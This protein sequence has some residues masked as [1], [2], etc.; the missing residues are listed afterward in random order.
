VSRFDTTLDEISAKDKK[1]LLTTLDVANENV[2]YSDIGK[3][4]QCPKIVARRLL[5]N[6]DLQ[7]TNPEKTF[8]IKGAKGLA[9]HL[10]NCC[11]PLPDDNIVAHIAPNS[12]LMIHRSNCVELNHLSASN[13][14]TSSWEL[15]DDSLFLV[16]I[17]I[18]VR[19]KVGV[20]FNITGIIQKADINIEDMN[21]TGDSDKKELRILIW[22]HDKNQLK[23]LMAT[24]QKESS[25]ASVSRLLKLSSGILT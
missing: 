16:P 11:H 20:L 6:I 3:G 1:K 12:G 15:D 5:G 23:K 22:V 7:T 17:H 19:N 18:H 25:V 9:V 21:I 14:M 10:S 24:L 4:N 13:K 8:Y 2:L